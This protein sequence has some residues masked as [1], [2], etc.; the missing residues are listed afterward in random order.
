MICLEPLFGSCVD[1]SFPQELCARQVAFVGK[2]QP[3]SCL[4]VVFGEKRWGGGVRSLVDHLTTKGHHLS[5]RYSLD[6]L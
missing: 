5:N 1:I 6:A 3:R 4:F 2:G